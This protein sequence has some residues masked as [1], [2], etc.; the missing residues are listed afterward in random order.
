MIS[1]L[2]QVAHRV[3]RPTRPDREGPIAKTSLPPIPVSRAC[4]ALTVQDFSVS[5][6]PPSASA[7]PGGVVTYTV[8]A[9]SVNGFAGEIIFDQS[10]DLP[11]GVSA[12]WDSN[13]CTVPAGGSC[14]SIYTVTVGAG[15][16]AGDTGLAFHGTYAPILVTRDANAT[17]HVSVG[18]YVW[19]KNFGGTQ[20]DVGYSVATDL[21]G[22]VLATGYFQG[23]ADF[24]GG[25]LTSAGREDIFLAKFAAD[26]SHV[27]SKHFGDTLQD[28]GFSVAVDASGNVFVTGEFMGTVDFGGGPLTSAGSHDIFL[29]KFAPNGSHLWSKRFGNTTDDVGAK[30]AVDA[31][32][33]VVVTG[34]FSGTVD[35]GGGPLTSQAQFDLFL[36]KFAPD[37]THLWSKRFGSPSNNNEGVVAVA[38]AVDASR[39]VLLT[40]H[41]QGTVDFGGGALT[42]VGPGDVFVA[43]YAS[44]GSHLWSKH[45]GGTSFDTGYGASVD[46]SGNVLVT[47]YFNG[48]VD[49]G[50]GLLTSAGASDIF[51]A[52]FTADGSHLWS[53]RFGDTSEDRGYSVATDA[54]NNVLFTGFFNGTVDFGGGLLTSAGFEDIYIA[55]FAADGSYLWAKR[56]G[57]T[58]SD[59]GF[60][61]VADSSGN[62][63]TIGV[64]NGTV[65][66]GGGPLT[67]AGSADIF[68]LRLTQ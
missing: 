30:L 49:F 51:V 60:G 19:A 22:N 14:S 21:S 32:G 42:S 5:V 15:V 34:V 13:R 37:G 64:F 20:G 23:T 11:S 53:N 62:V 39:N 48:T 24:G 38:V 40:G 26:G 55:K 31:S 25:P 18:S 52:K 27:W 29:A 57:S 63:F 58:G 12:V 17:L 68:V 8:T 67:S 44:D 16:A 47:G 10:T 3:R 45:F 61:V 43:K 66:F 50:G 59:L 41:F 46:G 28:S 56:F 4:P 6:L 33:N 2:G 36:A 35:F 1:P 9:S 7:P 65:D 54:S